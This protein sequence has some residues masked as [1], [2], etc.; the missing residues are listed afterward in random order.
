M[1]GLDLK[2]NVTVADEKA[3]CIEFS[4]FAAETLG[5][6]EDYI[7]VHLDHSKPL[8]FKGTFDPAF[9]LT[10]IS[11]D[12]LQPEKNE[13]YSKA[14]FAFFK[15]KLNVPGDRGYITFIDPGRSHIGYQGTTIQSL[16]PRRP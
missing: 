13:K 5:N 7:S 6:P 3:F 9:L 12:N 10:I 1:P 2:T 4:K 16:V 11:L 8:T 15:E 14:F